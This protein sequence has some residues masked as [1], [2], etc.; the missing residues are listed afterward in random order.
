MQGITSDDGWASS[1]ESISTTCQAGLPKLHR[2][3]NDLGTAHHHR[4]AP[5]VDHG[6]GPRP[7]DDLRSHA[8]RVAHGHGDERF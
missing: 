8:G 1:G 4:P 3:A 7:D 6:F 2:A 5:F